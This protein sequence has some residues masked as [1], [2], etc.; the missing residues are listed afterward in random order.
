MCASR[1]YLYIAANFYQSTA[2]TELGSV[3]RFSY[4]DLYNKISPN[5]LYTYPHKSSG[6][7]YSIDVEGDDGNL[8]VVEGSRHSSIP[9]VVYKNAAELYSMDSGRIS[10]ISVLNGNVYGA[11][12]VSDTAKVWKNGEQLYALTDGTKTASA[13]G[14]F[15]VS[16]GTGIKAASVENAKV[17]GYYSILGRKLAE[18]PESGLYIIQYD[19]GKA[20][21]KLKTGN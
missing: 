7:S 11:G 20:E 8:Y 4:N 1:Y 19:N 15:V 21:K 10:E 18:E 17:I 13:A 12:Y 5:V 9:D 6:G 3:T 14:I 2:N 16:D